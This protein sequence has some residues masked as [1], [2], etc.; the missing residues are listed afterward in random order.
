M[1]KRRNEGPLRRKEK[2]DSSSSATTNLYRFVIGDRSAHP[3][4]N[5]FY[6]RLV[7]TVLRERLD[8]LI[9]DSP[10]GILHE[11]GRHLQS[12]RPALFIRT[13]NSGTNPGH[14]S[15][16]NKSQLVIESVL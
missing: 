10:Q 1:L 15:Y 14:D 4:R 13:R 3:G 2:D 7:G 6:E 9:R 16:R 11:S 12:G 5:V 8:F